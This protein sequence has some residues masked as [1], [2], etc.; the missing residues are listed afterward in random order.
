MSAIRSITARVPSRAVSLVVAAAAAL[1]VLATLVLLPNERATSNSREA[2]SVA[3]RA[4]AGDATTAVAPVHGVAT[5]ARAPASAGAAA[6]GFAKAE[7]SVAAPPDTG[8]IA[9]PEVDERIVRTGSMDLSIRHGRFEDTWGDAQ[10]VARAFG[11][12]VIAASRSGAG[13]DARAGTITMRVPATRFDQAVDRLR[14]LSGAKVEQL[15]V[16][17]QDVTQEFV[18]VQSRLRHD[19]IVEGRLVALLAQT[20]TVSEVLSVQSRLDQVQEQI[21][22][23][24]G[25]IQY[26]DKLTTMST[27][28]ISIHERAAAGATHEHGRS[29]LGQAWHDAGARLSANVAGVIVW[30]GGA[31]PA[32]VLL[33]VVVALARTA[34]VRRRNSRPE[35]AISE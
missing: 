18:D 25:R 30:I 24:R 7:L 21:E 6:D 2:A 20:K 29:V 4:A 3:P 19:R 14:Q 28:D 1:L 34:W 12:Y 15:D 9:A 26:L 22:V 16:S 27:I 11:G 8:S 32:L 35:Q 33:S 31:I 5:D 23:E 17:S 13:D 10:A